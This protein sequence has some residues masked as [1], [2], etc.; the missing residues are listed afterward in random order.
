MFLQTFKYILHKAIQTASNLRPVVVKILERYW[1]CQLLH[2]AIKYK[3]NPLFSNTTLAL[4][5]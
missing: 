4:F 5:R 3:Y 1:K 2:V